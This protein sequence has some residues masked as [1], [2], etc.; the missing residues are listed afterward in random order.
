MQTGLGGGPLGTKA[1]ESEGPGSGRKEGPD[2]Q[3]WGQGHSPPRGEAGVDGGLGE[4][5]QDSVPGPTGCWRRWP[6]EGR[7]CAAGSSGP[8]QG[9]ERRSRR[10]AEA[11]GMP[12]CCGVL[13]LSLGTPRLG[14]LLLLGL[15]A[16]PTLHG[17]GRG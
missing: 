8:E 6:V 7:P 17:T 3:L 16:S 14:K 12:S 9:P 5:G 10:W 2:D 13:V 15:Q 1:W 4:R 11:L